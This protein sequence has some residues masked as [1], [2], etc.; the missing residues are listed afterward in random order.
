MASSSPTA[1][2]TARRVRTT[3]GR[4]SDGA[5]QAPPPAANATSTSCRTW[6]G[7]SSARSAGA[8]VLLLI[9]R[10]PKRTSWLRVGTHYLQPSVENGLARPGRPRHPRR[11][12][13]RRYRAEGE[14]SAPCNLL[15][16]GF[17]PLGGLGL[18][19]PQ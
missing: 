4:R 9:R 1:A 13:T 19:Q 18:L 5:P 14:S 3:H 12:N 7:S 8:P 17:R 2:P 11:N 16:S 10:R 6:T 15:S